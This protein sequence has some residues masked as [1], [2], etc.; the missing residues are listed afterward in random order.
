V[1]ALRPSAFFAGLL[2]GAEPRLDF[3]VSYSS[4]EHSGLGRYG[5]EPDADA[6]AAALAQAW[7]ALRPGGV[8]VLGVPMTCDYTG[9]IT[10]NAHRFYGWRRLA[11]IAGNFAVERFVG[12]CMAGSSM[13]SIAL[14]RKPDSGLPAGASADDWRQAAEAPQPD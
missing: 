6:D 9:A 4:L 14:L 3:V 7:C 8:F 1:R 12:P 11:S 2:A 5:E 10:F 13:G